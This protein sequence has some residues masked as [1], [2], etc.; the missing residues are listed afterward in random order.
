MTALVAGGHARERAAAWRAASGRSLR[1]VG[2]VLAFVAVLPFASRAQVAVMG[3][4]GDARSADV[5]GVVLHDLV[6]D[7]IEPFNRGMFRVTKGAVDFVVEPLGQGW[8][9]GVPRP[10]RKRVDKL[11]RN[12]AFP[13]RFTALLLQGRLEDSGQ[14]TGH[15][16]VNSTLG[17]A[18]LWDPAG[19]LGIPT[20]SEDVG[21]AFGVWGMEH[22]FYL[23]IPLM[24]PSSGRDGLGKLFDTALSPSTYVPGLNWF[25]AFNR[26]SLSLDTYDSLRASERDLYSLS[27][28]VWAVQRQAEVS[29]YTIPESAF[30][31]ADAD[32]SLGV[33]ALR[34][35]D[36]D[37]LARSRDGSVRLEA[38]GARLPYSAWMQKRPAPLVL[39]LPGIGGH[40]QGSTSVA[41]A[42]ML[43]RAGY[44]VVTVSSVFHAEFMLRGL[45]DPCPGYTPTDVRDIHAALRAVAAAVDERW[46]ER[47][48]EVSLAGY[49]LGGLEALF[50][51]AGEPVSLPRVRRFSRVVAINPPVD[52][53]A[54]AQCFDRFYDIPLGWPEE[55]RRR[56]LEDVALRAYTLVAEGLPEGRPLPFT[57]EESQF[58]VGLTGRDVLA[59]ALHA[60]AMHAA[61]GASAAAM[62]DAIRAMNTV[63]FGRYLDGILLPACQARE[64]G[65][66][67][68]GL[69]QAASLRAVV[70]ALAGDRRVRILTNADDFVLGPGG[71]DWLR[72]AFGKAR[73]TVFPQGGHLGNLAV[74][75]VR[76]AIVAALGGPAVP[77][78]PR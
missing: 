56:R 2:L 37:F 77:A 39:L 7:P 43:F 74:P 36:E 53:L 11:S 64:P 66:T 33:L 12:L 52:L 65:M 71:A 1:R 49:S 31:T 22:G 23:F 27:R 60:R 69:R 38:T 29:D 42:E 5:E 25:F 57:R 75:E 55:E 40:R 34:A 17:V 3:I 4:E 13:V 45:R 59:T 46:G 6:N 58:L 20:Y 30:A 50:L 51:A 63:S 8:S 54:A 18:G 70:G 32:L 67:A 19:R 26:L 16:L 68:E 14:E 15:F 76:E 78:H 47:I 61:R 48:T 24:G 62:R 9:C 72:E 28:T 44:S 35:R 73:V 41:L 21:Q 10:A